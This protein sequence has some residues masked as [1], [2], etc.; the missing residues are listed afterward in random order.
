M[1]RKRRSLFGNKTAFPQEVREI[2]GI[3][4][5]VKVEIIDAGA[6]AAKLVKTKTSIITRTNTS[7]SIRTIGTR[8]KN[9]WTTWA[10]VDLTG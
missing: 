1:E 2:W 5:I 4:T 6:T 7:T 3:K 9:D 10:K 8:T